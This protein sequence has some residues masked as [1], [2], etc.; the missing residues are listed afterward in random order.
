M[1]NLALWLKQ[2]NFRLD[3]VQTFLPTPMAIA[4]AMYHTQRN[5]LRKVTR[6][7]EQV[8]TVRASRMRRAVSYTHLDVY[9]RQI[10]PL[11]TYFVL[12]AF[13]AN[14]GDA[15]YRSSS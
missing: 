10:L 12:S 5:P 4:T 3:Q 15:R 7:S 6:S 2:N 1:L 14:V 11:S 9:K 8:E 13:L